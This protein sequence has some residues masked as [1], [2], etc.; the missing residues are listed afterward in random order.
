MSLFF[1]AFHVVDVVFEVLLFAQFAEIFLELNSTTF[2]QSIDPS[3]LQKS[4]INSADNL[5]MR[6]LFFERNIVFDS[7]ALCPNGFTIFL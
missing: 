7:F 1:E 5:F 4:L 6:A 2:S 3:G